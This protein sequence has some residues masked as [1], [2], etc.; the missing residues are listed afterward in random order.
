[1]PV[2]THTLLKHSKQGFQNCWLA[3]DWGGLLMSC[4]TP[5]PVIVQQQRLVSSAS[6]CQVQYAQSP[7]FTHR[8][9][10]GQC[11]SINFEQLLSINALSHKPLAVL[12]HVACSPQGLKLHRC[13]T[14]ANFI[15]IHQTPTTNF[16][17]SNTTTQSQLTSLASRV[18]GREN[19]VLSVEIGFT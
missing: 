5:P 2:T 6:R 3:G 19:S 15:I 7:L 10:S 8:F 11:L 1:M 13:S 16:T 17:R 14:R 4:Q 9:S 12:S 18:L